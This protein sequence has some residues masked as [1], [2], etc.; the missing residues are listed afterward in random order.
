VLPDPED[1]PG[2][3]LTYVAQENIE[4]E[5]LSA[6]H[7]HNPGLPQSLLGCASDGRG[8]EGLAGWFCS[9]GCVMRCVA[10]S[11][12]RLLAGAAV[13]SCQTQRE[14]APCAARRVCT[15]PRCWALLYKTG[16]WWR[17]VLQERVDVAMLP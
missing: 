16:A 8:W 13:I 15:A 11:A 12:V 10:A 6:L 9:A 5:A 4:L 1:R 14:M 2:Q 7:S 3:D 17:T